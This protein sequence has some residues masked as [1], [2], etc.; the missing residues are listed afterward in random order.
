MNK[1]QREFISDQ[2]KEIIDLKPWLWEGKLY[3]QIIHDDTTYLRSIYS[4]QHLS[5]LIENREEIDFLIVP[6]L[7]QTQILNLRLLFDRVVVGMN[8]D[9]DEILGAPGTS[10]NVETIINFSK[11]V[12]QYFKELLEIYYAAH[13]TLSEEK[14]HEVLHAFKNLVRPNLLNFQNYGKNLLSQIKIAEDLDTKAP[15]EGG[16]LKIGIGEDEAELLIDTVKCLFNKSGF[17]YIL[18][19]PSM[20][21]LLKIGMTTRSPLQRAKEL[22]SATGIPTPFEVSFSIYVNN[23]FKAEQYVHKMLAQYRLPTQKE[24]FKVNFGYAESIIVEAEKEFN[25]GAYGN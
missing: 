17:I 10:G 16:Y 5:D 7:I 9:Y 3:A 24:F 15:I 13:I 23:C 22:S 4:K 20:S 25:T 14:Y 18:T 11:G 2:A 6:I 1:N 19:N 8:I 12:C 21:G